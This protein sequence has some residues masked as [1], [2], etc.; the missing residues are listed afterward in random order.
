MPIQA[1][2]LSDFRGPFPCIRSFALMRAD[3]L[4][5]LG[6]G[7]REWFYRRMNAARKCVSLSTSAPLTLSNEAKRRATHDGRSIGAVVRDAV[8][9]YLADRRLADDD[10]P[11]FA[12]PGFEPLPMDRDA[13][14]AELLDVPS[15][16]VYFELRARTQPLLRDAA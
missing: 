6:E 9:G 12:V 14:I 11:V 13:V 8:A 16:V 7:R 1:P 2:G 4:K 3:A 15:A 10:A 5:M